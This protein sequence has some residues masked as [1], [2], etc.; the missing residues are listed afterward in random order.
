VYGPEQHDS[1][2]HGSSSDYSHFNLLKWAFWFFEGK[3]PYTP[4]KN[5]KYILLVSGG[6]VKEKT[7]KNPK[8]HETDVAF[9]GSLCYTPVKE[10]PRG[11]TP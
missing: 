9:F 6:C 7:D 11:L 4:P 1:L 8:K 5:P 3:S 2:R 10:T